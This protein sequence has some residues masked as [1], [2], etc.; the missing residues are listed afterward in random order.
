MDFKDIKPYIL[1]NV[2]TGLIKTVVS[3]SLSI[4]TVPLTIKNIGIENYGII[5]TILIFSGLSGVFDLGLSN[6]LIVFQQSKKKYRKEISSIYMINIIIFALILSLALFVYL[7]DINVMGGKLQ[8]SHETLNMI[9]FLAVMVL[10][11]SV[12]TNLLAAALEGDFKLQYV[13]LGFT[14]QSIIIYAGW[15]VFSILDIPIIYYLYLPLISSVLLIVFYSLL[16]PPIHLNFVK[17]DITSSRNALYTSFDFFKLGF[18]NSIHLPVTKYLIVLLIGDGRAIG[19]FELSSRLSLLVNNMLA[20]IS[21]PFFSI[22]GQMKSNKN[23]LIKL[24]TKTTIVLC[25]ISLSGY[26]VF[27]F[28]KKYIILYFF[29]E[30]NP[31]ISLILNMLIISCFILASSEAVQRFLLGIEKV[32]LVTRIKLIGLILN[33]LF[34]ILFFVFSC[35]SIENITLSYSFSIAFIGLFWLFY[36]CIIRR[37]I[38]K[39]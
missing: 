37:K 25:L 10:A 38:K 5:S 17:P 24:I 15:F 21:M 30:Y 16:L 3:L 7:F 32:Y 36:L 1:K 11:F 23:E 4:I 35:I 13:N 12:I 28:L 2:Y 39:T 6:A 34:I 26:I 27:L 22:S 20:Y 9:N 19:I 14:I 8:V 31:E 29:N 18:L 33:S